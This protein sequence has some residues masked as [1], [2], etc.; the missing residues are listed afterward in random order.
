VK[1]VGLADLEP[2]LREIAK[3]KKRPHGRSRAPRKAA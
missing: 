1:P 2:V 3:K